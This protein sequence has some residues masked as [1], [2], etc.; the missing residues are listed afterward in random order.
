[1]VY[2][3]KICGGEEKTKKAMTQH[4]KEEHIKKTNESEKHSKWY[5]IMGGLFGGIATAYFLIYALTYSLARFTVWLF[6]G[7]APSGALNSI[8]FLVAVIYAI[9]FVKVLAYGR[10]K[11]SEGLKWFGIGGFGL[12]LGLFINSVVGHLPT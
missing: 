1:M 7:Y 10:D 11:Q 5:Y 3:C 6:G 8:L 2:K 9:V 4:I 12:L